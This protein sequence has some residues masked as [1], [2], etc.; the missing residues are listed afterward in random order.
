MCR[1]GEAKFIVGCT[2]YGCLG[3]MVGGLRRGLLVVG[4]GGLVGKGPGVLGGCYAG[5]LLSFG[6][7]FDFPKTILLSG[8]EV[9]SGT[10]IV[11]DTDVRAIASARHWDIEVP[12]EVGE[13]RWWT[14]AYEMGYIRSQ[15]LEQSK[16]RTR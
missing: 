6:V 8:I 15:V 16:Q 7:F 9:C 2:R 5:L 12:T 3:I 10:A 4:V 11:E 14:R 13:E 1:R